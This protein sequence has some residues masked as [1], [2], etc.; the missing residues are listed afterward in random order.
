[1]RAR[2]SLSSRTAR[3]LGKVERLLMKA[4]QLKEPLLMSVINSENDQERAP[5]KEVYAAIV[6]YIHMD[7]KSFS[8]PLPTC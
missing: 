2:S 7:E 8:R 1:M 3:A 6:N 4:A 5:I